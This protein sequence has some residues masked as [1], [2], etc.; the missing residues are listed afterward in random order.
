MLTEG[1]G[2]GV[3]GQERWGVARLT[4]LVVFL[5]VIFLFS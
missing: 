1:K 2:G 5:G 3:Q 4:R